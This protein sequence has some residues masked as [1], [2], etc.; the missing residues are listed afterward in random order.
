MWEQVQSDRASSS[1]GIGS[2]S[3]PVVPTSCQLVVSSSAAVSTG[4]VV[5]DQVDF[6]GHS[7]EWLNDTQMKVAL[8]HA[9]GYMERPAL[10]NALA[11]KCGDK[12]CSS[13]Q[14]SV[15]L[16]EWNVYELRL[17]WAAQFGPEGAASAA[18]RAAIIFR[19]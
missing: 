17:A 11:F 14:C 15:L 12:L 4:V 1:S 6:A 8:G 19:L 13:K 7:G 3:E 16:D 18:A 2:W 5:A 10:L 9:P